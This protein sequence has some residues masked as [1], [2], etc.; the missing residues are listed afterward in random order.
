MLTDL[1]NLRWVSLT[2]VKIKFRE[3]LPNSQKFRGTTQSGR[4]QGGQQ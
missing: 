3:N 1:I 2:Y 4:S